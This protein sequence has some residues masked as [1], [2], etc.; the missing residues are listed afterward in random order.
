M[1]YET[2]QIDDVLDD[3]QRDIL[4]AEGI[5]ISD[6]LPIRAR[7]PKIPGRIWLDENKRWA[8]VIL[9]ETPTLAPLLRNVGLSEYLL[10]IKYMGM[11]VYERPRAA[12]A[13]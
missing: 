11:S 5:K 6:L 3:I 13:R 12:Y 4:Q 10:R 1:D 2:E 9:R 8:V 7:D